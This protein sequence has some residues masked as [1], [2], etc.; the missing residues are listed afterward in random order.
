MKEFTN[1]LDNIKVA[2][3][4]P[5]NWN[6][7][8]GNERQRFC[9]ECK[10]NVY[11]L[12]DMSRREAENFLINA[13]GRVCLKF[14]RRADGTVIT[15][16]CPVGWQAVKRR[17]SH[18]AKAF[19]SICAGIFGGIFAFNQFQPNQ[20]VQS[21]NSIKV[22]AINSSIL[23]NKV[24]DFDKVSAPPVKKEQ[25]NSKE[26]YEQVVGM[27]EMPIEKVNKNKINSK[28]IRR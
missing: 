3:P 17:V 14:Y 22:S 7:M 19:V 27:K 21:E 8:Y 23:P 2:S 18:T 25:L 4:C 6:E 20:N 13:E 24:E 12:S 11:N 15:K 10:L 26:N 9:S 28:T 1:S 16:D 5:A